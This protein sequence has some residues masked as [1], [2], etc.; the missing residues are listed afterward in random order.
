LDHFGAD[1]PEVFTEGTI[2]FINRDHPLYQREAKKRDTH[3]LNVARLI[4][5]EISLMKNAKDPRQAFEHQSVL[6]RDAFSD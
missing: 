6:L 3:I 4:A 5:Q 2:V 1:G